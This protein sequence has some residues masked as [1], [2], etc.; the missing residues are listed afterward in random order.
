MA[1]VAAV[2]TAC[3]RPAAT[4]LGPA[5]A[6]AAAT[7]AVVRPQL[8]LRRLLL[9]CALAAPAAASVA[10]HHG[11]TMILGLPLSP[12]FQVHLR[13]QGLLQLRQPLLPRLVRNRR[14]VRVAL[15]VVAR[16]LPARV[17]R[18]HWMV[19]CLCLLHLL[20]NL[21][22]CLLPTLPACRLCLLAAILCF[23]LTPV[24]S[25]WI[26]LPILPA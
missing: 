15:S 4:E 9:R 20:P 17:P 18:R 22:L 2:V 1:N 25:A 14:P 13:R 21:D 11:Q 12:L 24:D 7:T 26:L 6:A 3:L 5:S 8:A 19:V 10:A 23:A 16:T